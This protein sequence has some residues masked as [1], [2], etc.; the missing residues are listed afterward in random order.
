MPAALSSA[1]PLRFGSD[2]R[3]ELQPES[4]RL[5]VDGVPATLG[6]RAL[7]LLF[8]LAAEPGRLLGKHELMERVWPGLVVEENNLATQV[9]TLRKLLGGDVIATVPGRGYRFT[10]PVQADRP[11]DAPSAESA[12]S[13]AAAARPVT[14]LPRNLVR[15]HGRG[16]DLGAVAALVDARPLVTVVGPGGIGKTLLVQ[17]LLDARRG[18]YPH[19]VCWV[20]L[21]ATRDPAALPRAV[22]AALGIRVSDDDPLGTLCTALAPLSILIALDNAEHLVEALAPVVA[23]LLDAAPALKL[24]VTSQA[25]LHLNAE[26]VYRIA[27]LALP[28]DDAPAA[29]A[30][31]YGAVALFV[32]RARAADAHFALSDANAAAVVAL[33]RQ[34]DGLPL[35][36]ELAAAR[37]PML[38]VEQLAAAMQDR[39]RLLTANRNRVAPERQRTLRAALEWSHGLLEPRE[40]TVFRRLAVFAGSSSLEMIR[41]VVGDAALDGWDVLDGLGDLVDRSLVAVEAGESEDDAAPRYRLLE[42]TRAYAL[43]QLAAVGEEQALRR[44]HAEALADH[45]GAQW[46]AQFRAGVLQRDWIRELM[47]DA[48][49]AR[50]A[51]AWARASG[52]AAAA[53]AI[54]ATIMQSR[55]CAVVFERN[56]VADAC[57]PLLEAPVDARLRLHALV[58]LCNARMHTRPHR[59][60]EGTARAVRLARTLVNDGADPFELYLAL[61]SHANL[62]AWTARIDDARAAIDELQALE[63]RDWPPQRRVVGH[64]ALNRLTHML[65]G[66]A[67]RERSRRLTRHQL[68]L[69]SACGQELASLLSDCIDAELGCGNAEEAVRIGQRL[70]AEQAGVGARDANGHAYACLN[71]AAALLALDRPA[72]ARPLLAT[73]WSLAPPREI[74]PFVADHLALLAALE[75][76]HE[77]AARLAGYA[78]AGYRGRSQSR[79]PNETTSRD[80]GLVLACEA[81]GAARGA[82]LREQGEALTDA[83]V[84]ALAFE[85]PQRG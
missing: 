29:E 40:R 44:R 2:G 18:A 76:R 9:S 12:E 47:H 50:S 81:L 68:E 71:L 41:R 59:I 64:A 3:F 5:L 6:A 26:V 10:A 42:S 69:G 21:A 37:A 38:G 70:L 67:A 14:R 35:A 55:P 73:A 65:P 56:A 57:E 30:G 17:H 39:L 43:E 4:Y 32:E 16:D 19:G 51:F 48:D 22:G 72:E 60:G 23:A 11:A 20:E 7:D 53:L 25:P 78:D 31:N 74:Q 13:V 63:D 28:P 66:A 8:T 58:A 34:L 85:A 61:A 54:G 62:C 83:E 33:C 36:I 80:R 79:E 15:L 84:T 24:V 1:A 82:A 77:A 52:H 75:G 45:F 27:P 49:N 46:D